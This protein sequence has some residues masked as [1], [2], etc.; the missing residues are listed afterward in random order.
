VVHQAGASLQFLWHEA[1]RSISTPPW[2]GCRFA[3]NNILLMRNSNEALVVFALV[4]RKPI[5][6]FQEHTLTASTKKLKTNLV[7]E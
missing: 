6:F 4:R 1:T 7:I 3:T 2:M 5:D